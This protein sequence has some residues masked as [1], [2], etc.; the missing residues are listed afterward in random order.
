MDMTWLQIITLASLIVGALALLAAATL[1]LPRHVR[2]QR[3]A[4]VPASAD[5][6]LAL[7]SSNQGY[8]RFNPYRNTDPK[9]QIETF[10]PAQGVG[11]GFR[12]SSKDT[13]GSQTVAAVSNSAVDFDIDLGPMGQP[14][15]RIEVRPAASGTQ[16]V[17]TMQA[18]M[19]HNPIG[20]V[21]GLFMDR[22]VGPT[23][24]TGLKNLSNLSLAT[25]RP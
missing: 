18:D 13:K 20:R 25:A 16:V 8:Q 11:S 5:A 1:L 10:G 19:G 17:W 9:L 22:I 7:A 4:H 23:F 2:V 3:S 21:M 14:R 6:I 15:Q 12:F 24:E